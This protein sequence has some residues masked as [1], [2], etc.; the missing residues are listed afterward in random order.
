MTLNQNAFDLVGPWAERAG[1]IGGACHDRGGARVLDCGV[2]QPGGVEAGLLMARAAL[3]GL[4]DVA[5]VPAAAAGSAFA[6]LWV[7]CPWPAVAVS[8]GSPVAACLAAQY[9]GWKVS[10]PGYF[11]MASGPIRSAIGREAI[12]DTIGLRERARV[13]V[14]LLET[15][16]L[17]PDEVCAKLAA[18]AGVDPVHVVLLVA[19]TASIAGSLQVVAR[20]LETALH[21]LHEEHFDLSR[22]VAGRGLAPLPPVPDDD[23]VAIGR[24]N[25]AILY[26]GHVVLEV[27]GDDAS[28]AEIGP[29][30]V[31]RASASYGEPFL[32][33]F[34]RAGHDFYALDPA[35]FAPAVVEFVNLDTGRRHRFGG[36]A[37]EIVERSF[38][39]PADAQA[40]RL[41]S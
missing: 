20:S 30:S 38:T 1:E 21:K 29:R 32:A 41:D 18:D 15:S 10:T 14:G 39:T 26:G 6:G 11:A 22:I 7:D 4:G 37:P 33:L 31:S 35:L 2:K 13:A 5:V 40:G 28:L 27:T 23:L 9:A 19:R 24:T 36:L 12:F 8:S 3:G 34:A 17:P 16:K 25:D